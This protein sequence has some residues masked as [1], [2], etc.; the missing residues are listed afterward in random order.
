VVLNSKLILDY[1]VAVGIYMVMEES[2]NKALIFDTTQSSWHGIS[3]IIK[4]PIGHF[5][6]SLVV[7]YLCEP[8]V[9]APSHARAL[10]AP[11]EDHKSD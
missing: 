10:Y 8:S 9:D 7:Y 4:A 2:H 5:R 6:K 1:M 3:R 11:T